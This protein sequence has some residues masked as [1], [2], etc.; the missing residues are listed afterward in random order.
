VEKQGVSPSATDLATGMVEGNP[1]FLAITERDPSMV[2]VIKK[3]VAKKF[4]EK[5]GE[6]VKSQLRAWVTEGLK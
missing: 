4:I 6:P 3:E 1:V 5:S 2:N